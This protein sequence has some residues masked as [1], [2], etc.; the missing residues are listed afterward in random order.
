MRSQE[1]A[2]FTKNKADT[3]EGLDGV[4][5]ALK[6]LREYYAQEGK[7]HSAA[8][9]SSSSIVGLLEVVESDFSR[10][11]AEMTAAEENAQ[12]IY[13]RESYANKIDKTMK[14]KDVTYK[15]K[16]SVGLDKQV[17]V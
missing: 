3:E 7:A 10:G 12:T 13:D 5:M 17:T 8:E 1:K 9:G 4:K 11:L 15:T 16:E 2:T 6:V 14:E